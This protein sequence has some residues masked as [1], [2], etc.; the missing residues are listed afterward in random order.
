MFSAVLLYV[1]M[2]QMLPFGLPAL[3]LPD[4]FSM[5]THP[6]NFAVL[7]LILAVPVLYC[8]RNFF[9]GASSPSSTAT[10]TWTPWWPSAP[11]APL[12]TAW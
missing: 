6:M 2:G 1:S 8:G 9:Q 4:L 12:R 11:A 7:Q 5:H 3:P 10:P